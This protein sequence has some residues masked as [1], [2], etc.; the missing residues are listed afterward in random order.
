MSLKTITVATSC[1]IS[2]KQRVRIIK[3]IG[4]FSLYLGD[5]SLSAVDKFLRDIWCECCGH[6]SA[7]RMG[8][9]EF[10]KARKL[11]ELSIG[12]TLLYEYDFGSTTEI[13][14]TVV[15]EISRTKQKEKVQLLARNVPLEEKCDQCGAQATTVNAWENEVL[16]DECAEGVE[17]ED[18]LMP[19][20]NSP[21]SGEYGY[22]GEYDIWLFDSKK[23]FPQPQKPKSKR[24]GVWMSPEK[25]EIPAEAKWSTISDI[26]QK[27]L[28]DNVFCG[29]CGVTTIVDYKI[30]NSRSDIVLQGKCKK[31]GG[32]IAR[33]VEF[34]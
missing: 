15:D 25:E 7:F 28:L 32:K 5:A 26:N 14:I 1:A 11:S 17:D 34:E 2:S 6:M 33:V 8:G 31:C 27:K 23:P 13:I 21:R 22:D 19:I 3:I 18:A 9:R 20:V 29:K 10:G 24:S 12:D 30:E 4:F 16:C